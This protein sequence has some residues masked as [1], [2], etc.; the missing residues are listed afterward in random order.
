M[1]SHSAGRLCQA[2]T[3]DVSG[4]VNGTVPNPP[5]PQHPAPDR[6]LPSS[7]ALASSVRR[8]YHHLT[9][10]LMQ[11][12]NVKNPAQTLVSHQTKLGLRGLMKAPP[13]RD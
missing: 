8:E 1:H 6:Q 10:G 13:N 5:S 3:E 7:G 2:D 4:V 11:E 12:I 9:L